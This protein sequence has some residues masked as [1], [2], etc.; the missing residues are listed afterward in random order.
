MP[1]DEDPETPQDESELPPLEE[2]A[3]TSQERPAPDIFSKTLGD[4]YEIVSLLGKGAFGEVY[5]ARDEVLGRQVAIKRIRLDAFVEPAQLEE[6]KARFLREAQVAA[7]LQHKNI[8]TTHDIVSKPDTSLIVL[9]LVEGDTLQ[10]MLQAR[11]RLPLDE[12]LRILEQVADAL[13]HAHGAGIVH[14]DIKPGNIMIEPSGQVK[15]MDFGIAKVETGANLT[16][17]GLIMGTPN[18]MAPEQARGQKVDGR[19]DLF[20]VGCVLYECV[21]GTKPFHGES[22]TAILLKIISEPPPPVDF[23]Q[24]GLPPALDGVMR[25][26]MAKEA[27]QRYATGKELMAAIRQAVEHGTVAEPVRTPGSG[28]TVVAQAPAVPADGGTPPSRRPLWALAAAGVVAMLLLGSFVGVLA[29]RSMGGPPPPSSADGGPLIVEEELGFFGRVLGREPRLFITIPTE[30]DLQVELQTTLSSATSR[31]GDEFTAQVRRPV[32]IE[33][34]EAVRTGARVFGHL[35][36][37]TSAEDGGGRGALTLEFDS[38]A[39][40]DGRELD[41]EAAP[42]VLRAPAPK[43]KNKKGLIAGIAGAGAAIGGIFGGKKGALAGA[44]LGGVAGA[45]IAYSE[46]GADIELASGNTFDVQLAAPVV[47]TRVRDPEGPDG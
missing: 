10:T 38:V 32:E 9:E 42:V 22:I 13:D 12:T 31:T 45:G 19:A 3:T 26:A 35:S 11:G 21:T 34:V 18:Y 24:A 5:R 47:I 7:Q 39:L 8:V 33:D 25:R 15:V 43:K 17:T 4:R 23:D 29:M 44:A 30:T 40:A 6:V 27:A 20:S 16:S 2:S 37:V 36:A 41:I 46:K 14:R 1:H 28:G